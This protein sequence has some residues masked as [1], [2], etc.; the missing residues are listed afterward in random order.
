MAVVRCC[1]GNLVITYVKQVVTYEKFVTFCRKREFHC[2]VI[3]ACDIVV[4]WVWTPVRRY[5]HFREK[6]YVHCHPED[7]QSMLLSIVGT[8]L[9]DHMVSQQKSK[10][11]SLQRQPIQWPLGLMNRSAA[12]RLLGLRIRIPPRATIFLL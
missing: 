3:V 7:G 12:T 2:V 9:Q 10:C 8:C 11:I 5:L 6:Q 4:F 1:N